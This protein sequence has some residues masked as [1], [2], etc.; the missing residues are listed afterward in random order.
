MYVFFEQFDWR[1]RKGHI[2]YAQL[3]NGKIVAQGMAIN[4]PHHLSYPFLFEFDGTTYCLPESCASGK[5]TLYRAVQFPDRWESCAEI[6]NIPVTDAT[7][8]RHDQRW[9]L[10]CSDASFNNDTLLIYYAEDP[11]GPWIPHR[12]N[13]VKLDVHSVRPAGPFFMLDD[14][15]YRPAQVARQHMVAGSRSIE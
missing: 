13:P 10:F 3:L 7:I 6:L 4:E 1:V 5:L 12:S 9:W 2:A 15:L 14:V 8:V 11:R